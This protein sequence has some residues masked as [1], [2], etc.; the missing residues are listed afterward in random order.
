MS[1]PARSVSRLAASPPRRPPNAFPA[2]GCRP[3]DA[4]SP[5][6]AARYQLCRGANC[7]AV[8]TASSLTSISGLALPA[9]GTSTLR[10]WL[11]DQL[12]HEA[13]AGA[14]APAL[15]HPPPRPAPP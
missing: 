7:G 13:P 6:T 4:G 3:A 9:A 10:V 2:A 12:G 15:G 5:I 14:G 8:Q 1:P 11:V